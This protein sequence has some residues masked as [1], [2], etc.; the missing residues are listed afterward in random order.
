MRLSLAELPFGLGEL[1]LRLIERGLE[2]PRIYF[3]KDLAFAHVRAFAIVL[4][5]QV[6]G[7]LRLDIGVHVTIECRYPVTVSGNIFPYDGDHANVGRGATLGGRV[8]LGAHPVSSTAVNINSRA[9]ACTR[10]GF[11]GLTFSPTSDRMRQEVQSSM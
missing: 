2:R 1:T 3:E 6:S 11:L 7:N 4:K 10:T 9:T 5:D 8:D